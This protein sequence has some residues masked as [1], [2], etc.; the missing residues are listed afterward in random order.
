MRD[1]DLTVLK[2]IIIYI[3]QI[4]GTISRFKLNFD[5]FKDDYVMKNAI[6]MCLLQIGELSGNLTDEF[7]TEHN[8]MPWR[9]IIA[10]RNRAA[11]GY[12]SMD[13]EIIWDIVT[14]DIPDLKIY[15]EN[16]I[17]GR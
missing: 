11:H 8:K 7:K 16:I 12:G 1:R 14:D 9:D 6:A 13:I 2:K 3:N 5:K 15:C 4:N 10:F 17:E